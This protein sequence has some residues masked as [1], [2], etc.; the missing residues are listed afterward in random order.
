MRIDK[1]CPEDLAEILRRRLLTD[2]MK[3]MNIA[4]LNSG[5]DYLHDHEIAIDCELLIRLIKQDFGPHILANLIHLIRYSNPS[6]EQLVELFPILKRF[7][8]NLGEDMTPVHISIAECLPL[9]LF[10]SNGFIIAL[11]LLIDDVPRV[12]TLSMKAV[13]SVLK[14]DFENEILLFH[15]VLQKLGSEDPASLSGVAIEWLKMIEQRRRVDTHGE[16]LCV[17]VDEFFMVREIFKL[18]SI[19][20]PS[21]S[22]LLS[23]LLSV[24]EDFLKKCIENLEKHNVDCKVLHK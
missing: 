22:C 5:L 8:Y 14:K 20:L 19:D 4:L 12:R 10:E 15:D 1:E 9:I 2:D 24:R 13:S 11:R 21:S 7:A 6:N 23:N 18:I 17:L 3:D 16:S